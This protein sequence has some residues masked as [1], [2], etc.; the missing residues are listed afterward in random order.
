MNIWK[1]CERVPLPQLL[2]FV[3]DNR[4]KTVPVADDGSYQLIATNCI[5][6]ESLYPSY[7]KVRYLS[8]ETYKNWFRAHPTPGDIIFVCKEMLNAS[9]SNV[10]DPA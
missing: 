3:V 2:S 7:D 4:G 6:N 5:R 1:D 8:E 10:E 9:K